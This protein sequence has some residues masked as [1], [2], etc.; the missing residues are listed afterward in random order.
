LVNETNEGPEV[1]SAGRGGEATDGLYA[2]AV[3]GEMKTG[4]VYFPEAKLELV[5]V[6]RDAHIAAETGVLVYVDDFDW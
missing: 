6:E 3:I 2:V 4:E 5:T 1:C